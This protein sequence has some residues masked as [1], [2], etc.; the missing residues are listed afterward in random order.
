[1]TYPPRNRLRLRQTGRGLLLLGV[2]LM[3]AWTGN[4]S[5]VH[6]LMMANT[7]D[8]TAYPDANQPDSPAVFIQQTH[9]NQPNVG[10]LRYTV[11]VIQNP[12]SGHGRAIIERL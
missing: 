4:A 11:H 10:D 3:I 1:M 6:A 2:V 8:L 12:E 9:C 5:P 7:C